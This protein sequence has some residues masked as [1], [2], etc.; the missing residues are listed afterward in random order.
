[1][2]RELR[3]HGCSDSCE[4]GWMTI[5]HILYIYI[6]TWYNIYHFMIYPYIISR[7]IKLVLYIPW[8]W[9][10]YCCILLWL[11]PIDSP[12]EYLMN[13]PT[14]YPLIV[15]WYSQRFRFFYVHDIPE[16]AAHCGWFFIPS[17]YPMNKLPLMVGIPRDDFPLLKVEEAGMAAAYVRS[18]DA[19][20]TAT[21]CYSPFLSWG[22]CWLLMAKAMVR[23]RWW[24]F[25]WK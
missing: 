15:D 8:F 9:Q 21:A 16:W 20:T 19:L 1:M 11:I 12:S 5:N 4:M 2:M 22:Y 7:Y 10:W 25:Y 3:C 6:Y 24:I 23:D 14:M 18:G 13:I 17:E